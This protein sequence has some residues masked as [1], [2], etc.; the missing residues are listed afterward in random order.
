MIKNIIIN[1][2]CLILLSCIS[3][4]KYTQP[5]SLSAQTKEI[6]VY[7]TGFIEKN[8]ALGVIDGLNEWNYVLNNNI[9]Y[10]F[11][12]GFPITNLKQKI[13]EVNKN[14]IIIVIVPYIVLEDTLISKKL[15]PTKTIAITTK[16]GHVIYVVKEKLKNNSNI[17]KLV[18]IHEIGHTLG[19]EHFDFESIMNRK[20]GYSKYECIDKAMVLSVA[21]LNDL[22]WKSMRYC[23]TDALQ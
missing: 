7:I 8:E 1:L 17:T 11:I 13:V 16:F 2:L 10:K 9:K 18:V 23:I 22:N 6:P 21:F 14:G 20:Y 19:I 4:G 3:V 5:K 15:S 12:G